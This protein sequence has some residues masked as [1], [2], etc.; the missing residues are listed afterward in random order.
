MHRSCASKSAD[1]CLTYRISPRVVIAILC[2]ILGGHLRL[3]RVG[4]GPVQ[5]YHQNEELRLSRE[6]LDDLDETC[7]QSDDADLR[8]SLDY[9]RQRYV[10][11]ETRRL[12]AIIDAS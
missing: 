12:G 10:Q 7:Q 1:L 8:S 6:A 2:I 3:R 9:C 5:S 4:L 11:A